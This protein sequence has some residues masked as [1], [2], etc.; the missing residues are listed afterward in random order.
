MTANCVGRKAF[1]GRPTVL[2]RRPISR[3]D[4][5]R[6]RIQ[7]RCR[8]AFARRRTMFAR[9]PVGRSEE[10]GTADSVLTCR[11]FAA[12]LPQRG[13]RCG[14]MTANCVGR[15]ANY[16]RKMACRQVREG[17]ALAARGLD[18]SPI[19]E[20]SKAKRVRGSPLPF[21]GRGRERSGA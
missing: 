21:H 15:K 17:T 8:R 11:V 18:T 9:W 16:V 10:E 5:S 2:A 4:K 14:E 13:R 3:S 1:A 12:L 7:L 19:K 20:R 6:R